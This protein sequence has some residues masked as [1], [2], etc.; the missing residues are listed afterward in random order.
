MNRKVKYGLF[1][2]LLILV[3][4][5]GLTAVVAFKKGYYLIYDWIFYLINY[6]IILIGLYLY[7][8]Q[9][10]DMKKSTKIAI[11]VVLIV[12]N[13]TIIYKIGIPNILISKSSDKK[14]ELILKE[15]PGM[16]FK[17]MR[18]KRRGFIFGR[19]VDTLEG[20][21][22]YKAIE[23]KNYKVDWA[24]DDNA[25]FTYQTNEEGKLSEKIYNFRTTDTISYY[26]VLPS[27]EGKWVSKENK[28]NYFIYDGKKII[29]SDGKKI[30]Y[31]SPKN[32]TQYGV[33]SLVIKSKENPTISV[34]INS[35][36][37]FGE[38][39]IVQ[40][41]GSITVLENSLQKSGYKVFYKQDT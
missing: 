24:S 29:Y 36:S 25:V 41:G 27:I 14:H 8:K 2:L 1:G 35:D 31:Y 37:V 17:T 12:I 9:K 32:S 4:F 6:L 40:P 28:K 5:Q 30:Y 38:H 13:G 15:Y 7:L 22:I 18:L 11:T 3:I 20:T 19:Q 23:N 39:E 26:Y 21:A 16:N 10:W 34:V 33:L